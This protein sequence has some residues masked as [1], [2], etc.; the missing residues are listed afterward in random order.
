MINKLSRRF[1]QR[2]SKRG[3]AKRSVPTRFNDLKHNAA[4][5]GIQSRGHQITD[6][7][8]VPAFAGTNG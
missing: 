7:C 8:W 4:Q 3:W 1:Y 2:S 5:A 6:K